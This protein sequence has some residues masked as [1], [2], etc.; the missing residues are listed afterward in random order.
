MGGFNVSAEVALFKANLKKREEER[1]PLPGI[2][3][4][5]EAIKDLSPAEK[6]ALWF[7]LRL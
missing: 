2:A 5:A 1:V 3:A 4:L 6:K 7:L